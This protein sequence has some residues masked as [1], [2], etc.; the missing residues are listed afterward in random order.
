M[1]YWLKFIGFIGIVFLMPMCVS[2][3]ET[4]LQTELQKQIDAL[5][6]QVQSLIHQAEMS[7]LTLGR[8]DANY[9]FIRDLELGDTGED[10]R[11]LQVFLNSSVETRIAQSGVG[12]PGEETDY[13]GQLTL[14]A[15]IAYQN[16]YASEVLSPIGLSSGTG[17][18]GA[19]TREHINGTA[20]VQ[21]TVQTTTE[22][23]I[24]ISKTEGF[25]VE[26]ENAD[27]D[28]NERTVEEI[29]EEYLE[30]FHVPA[31]YIYEDEIKQTVSLPF[32]P[33]FV[34][35]DLPEDIQYKILALNS[36]VVVQGEVFKVSSTNRSDGS[37][38]KIDSQ[39]RLDFVYSGT[40]DMHVTM[41]D[42]ISIGKHTLAV[43]YPN[44]RV[45]PSVP[46]YVKEIEAT[47]PQFWG[48]EIERHPLQE[49]D[50]VILGSGFS[51]ESN[52]V[53]VTG[54]ILVDGI[55]S[56]DGNYLRFKAPAGDILSMFPTRF[57]PI[58]EE[59]FYTTDTG[60]TEPRD[61]GNVHLMDLWVENEYG[62]SNVQA[63][64]A[65]SDGFYQ[66]IN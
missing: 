15:V 25:P 54:N 30:G 21:T 18:V 55:V 44:G 9:V 17:Y 62:K 64:I 3:G 39:S 41:P 14:Y 59:K 48:M 60:F 34:E 36:N 61:I 53:R 45:S 47:P 5:L 23:E 10:V 33:R 20:R 4:D 11:N 27:E 38:I 58:R 42:D 43:H 37:Y 22:K 16:Y 29:V 46:I 7:G 26:D 49:A 32:P 50:I 35:D 2:A 40:Y 66:S 19:K 1:K 8:V 13:F 6:L 28:E 52:T 12:S 63:Y 24:K 57:L 51:K 31:I 56:E 65:E